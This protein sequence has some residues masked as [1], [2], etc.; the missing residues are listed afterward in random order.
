[1]YLY[2]ISSWRQGT[3]QKVFGILLASLYWEYSK[4]SCA[5]ANTVVML[6]VSPESW[7]V[8]G[9][10]LHLKGWEVVRLSPLQRLS[11][12]AKKEQQE[13]YSWS[14]FE[15]LN[16]PQ[17]LSL[18]LLSVNNGHHSGCFWPATSTW[19]KAGVNQ[20]LQAGVSYREVL[21]VQVFWGGRQ[22]PEGKESHLSRLVVP[23]AALCCYHW[24]WS[25]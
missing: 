8:T 9:Y 10:E 16:F 23:A 12:G 5:K 13:K 11:G 21:S 4:W 17:A 6:C 7:Q 20:R 15:R 22:E 3:S 19:A 14:D 24:P 25:V 1:M 18:K 2:K